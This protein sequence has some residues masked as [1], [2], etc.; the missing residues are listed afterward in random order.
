ML[1]QRNTPVYSIY[2]SVQ[3]EARR[4]SGEQ[5]L[6]IRAVNSSRRIR[7]PAK[8]ALYL[9][10]S[11]NMFRRISSNRL[12]ALKGLSTAEG[13]KLETGCGS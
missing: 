12:K 5:K 1:R 4:K 13:V 7:Q 6:G 3:A 8:A 10:R 11:F 2:I 9:S